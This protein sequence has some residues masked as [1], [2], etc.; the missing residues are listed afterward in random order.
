MK[1]CLILSRSLSSFSGLFCLYVVDHF[2]QAY[3]D[4]PVRKVVHSPENSF[5]PADA[6]NKSVLIRHFEVL[7]YYP[8]QTP[9]FFRQ[10]AF[11]FLEEVEDMVADD[12]ALNAFQV[13][14]EN[15]DLF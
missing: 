2:F 5:S 10:F 14:N 1:F 3:V 9:F 13:L 12:S 11:K 8:Q 15:P 6:V 4:L 7:I